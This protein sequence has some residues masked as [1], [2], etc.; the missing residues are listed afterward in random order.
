MVR[1]R[2][3]SR[4]SFIKTASVGTVVA[5]AGCTQGGSGGENDNGD[6]DTPESNEQ[7]TTSKTQTTSGGNELA[8]ELTIYTL[9]GSWGRNV[10]KAYIDTFQSE[11]EVNINH[12]TYGNAQ[13]LMSKIKAGSTDAHVV[14]QNDPTVYQGIQE[15]LWAPLR[16]ENIPN[17]DEIIAFDPRESPFDPGDEIHHIPQNYGGYGAIYNHDEIDEPSE[18]EDFYTDQV[19]GKLTLPQWVS[20]VVAIAAKD[21]GIDFNTLSESGS[22]ME[23]VWDRVEMQNEY[24]LEWYDSGATAQQ[25]FTDESAV[26]GSF[27]VGRTEV[28]R[29]EDGVPVSYTVPE[30]G[31]LAWIDSWT[32][33]AGLE[34]PE[35]Y[36]SE[37]FLNHLLAPEPSTQIADLI[38]YAQT[39]DVEDPPEAYQ[40]NPDI[41]YADRLQ[42]WD[43]SVLNP[44]RKAWQKRFQEI[45]RA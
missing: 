45:I 12:R 25:F 29:E 8:E 1:S 37:L 6:T 13:E 36:T 30:D 16:T 15:N 31:S 17:L 33:P 5:L 18:W 27:W 20:A 32:I 35:R 2:E 3:H 41:E 22:K 19:A 21:I 24:M 28:L 7:Q 10:K 44:N 11:Y 38:T 14:D 4:R 40:N 26:A 9:G 39:V 23:K 43:H 42:A 34:D